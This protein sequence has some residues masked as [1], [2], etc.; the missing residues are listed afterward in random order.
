MILLWLRTGSCNWNTETIP[1]HIHI[2]ICVNIY[3]KNLNVQ[4]DSGI[5]LF[6]NF[7]VVLRGVFKGGKGD[8]RAQDAC[9]KASS[10]QLAIQT[11]QRARHAQLQPNFMMY[12]AA[13]HRFGKRWSSRGSTSQGFLLHS[14]N[15]SHAVASFCYEIK[16][17]KNRWLVLLMKEIIHHLEFKKTM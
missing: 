12:N 10:E 14:C 9:A 16:S 3:S 15:E 7:L 2:Y 17:A 4:D 1:L 13:G 5:I 8:I 11:L 6:F